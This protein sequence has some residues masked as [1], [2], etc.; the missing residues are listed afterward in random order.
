VESWVIPPRENAEFV[1]HMESVLDLY[2]RPYDPAHP[3]ICIDECLKQLVKEILEPIR[4]KPG[5]KERY[6]YQYERNGTANIFMVCNPLEGWRMAKVTERR[7]AIDYAYLLK[8]IVDNYWIDAEKITIVQDQLNTHSPVSLYKAFEPSEAQ[9][10]L[11]RLQFCYTP[12]HG[13]WLNM[14]EIELSILSRQCLD[15]RI[16]EL[17]TLAC[18]VDA[19]VQ[20]RNSQDTWIDWRFTTDDARIKL[21]KLYPSIQI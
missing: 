7:T 8:E 11:Q 1:Y 5:Q 13:S 16:G 2:Q 6:D 20:K 9:R 3:F 21:K 17:S 14:A 18:E 15:R 4:A 19:W 12:K 10:I